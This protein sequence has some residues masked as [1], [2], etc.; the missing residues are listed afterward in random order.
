[1][2]QR[3]RHDELP[4]GDVTLT[5]FFKWLSGSVEFVT[6][7]GDHSPDNYSPQDVIQDWTF[8]Q[9]L[10]AGKIV[11]AP[12]DAMFEFNLWVN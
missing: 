12:G 6:L 2:E 3:E 8:T 10:A 1:M 9:D 5:R 4:D 11:P 7:L